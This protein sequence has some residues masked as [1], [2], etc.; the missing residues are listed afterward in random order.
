MQ[1]ITI[2]DSCLQEQRKS[3]NVISSKKK[4]NKLEAQ[5]GPNPE[6]CG[7]TV[8]SNMALYMAVS[9]LCSFFPVLVLYLAVAVQVLPTRQ[10]LLRISQSFFQ[11]P[12]IQRFF[13]ILVGSAAAL[14]GKYGRSRLGK[15]AGMLVKL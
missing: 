6:H 11:F 15:C 8:R 7:I 14:R 3:S 9:L 10:Q 2:T 5:Q 12:P 1:C 13:E 4:V